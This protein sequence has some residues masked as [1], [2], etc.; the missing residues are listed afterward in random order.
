MPRSMGKKTTD[1]G[2]QSDR[3]SS[4]RFQELI[5]A[6]YTRGLTALEAAEVA[7]L[8][9]GFEAEDKSFYG[10]LLERVRVQ[11]SAARKRR[12]S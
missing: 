6:K 12:V 9:T 7:S 8:E 5:E 2:T 1:T 10:P 4:T 3:P 11:R